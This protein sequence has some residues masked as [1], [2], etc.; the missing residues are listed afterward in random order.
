MPVFKTVTLGCK[1]NQYETEYLRQGLLRAGFHEAIADEPADLCVVN[2]CTVTLESDY[3]SRKVIRALSRENPR[4]E[5]IVMGCYASR[6]PQELARLPR[7]IHVMTDKSRLR[8]L[9]AQL[10][11][12]DAPDGISSFDRLHRAYVKV[13]DGCT[14]DCAYCIVPKVR[15]T[16]VSRPA[17]QVVEEVRRLVD[18]G[19]REV[20]LTGV[21][22]GFY[23]VDL[24]HS[25]SDR[26]D[27]AALVRR[28]VSIEGE[29]RVRL[30]SLEAAEVEPELLSLMASHPDRICPHF[31]L[32]LQSGSDAVLARMRRRLTVSQFLARCGE[33]RRHLDEPAITTDVIVGFPGEG[34]P[35]FEA[36]CRV[37][38][39]AGFS[40]VHV[41]R[42]SARGGTEAATL[43]DQVP[44]PIKRRRAGS[45]VA[46]GRRLRLQ[47]AGKLV[48]K[49]LQVV[50]ESLAG[51]RRRISGTADRY[52]TVQF[53]AGAEMMDRIVRVVAD[54]LLDDGVLAGRVEMPRNEPYRTPL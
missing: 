43:P 49:R 7:V 31:H 24:P 9:V 44:P 42:F 40:R 48:G 45:L 11:R 12:S 34:E 18:A 8:Q 6:A 5:I 33:I 53:P 38:R 19:H 30:S 29:F 10:G 52:V 50:G 36:S 22:L 39:E 54:R 16:L 46:I 26:T 4:T 14:M 41:F 35:D 23:G 2:T 15:P 27:L 13:Q 3:K 47:Y 37:V 25:G 51:D 32:P 1:V 17:D 28:I 20:V 21:H